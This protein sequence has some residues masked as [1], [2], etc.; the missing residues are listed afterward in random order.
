MAR[1]SPLAGRIRLGLRWQSTIRLE[2][3]TAQPGQRPFDLGPFACHRVPQ[4]AEPMRLDRWLLKHVCSNWN[5][6]Q[7]LIAS[8]QVWVLGPQSTLEQ[9]RGSV[10]IPRLR[11]GCKGKTTLKPQDFVYFPKVM[12]PVPKRREPAPKEPPG[13]LLRRLIY[14]D[15]DFLA[16]DKPIGWSVNPGKHVGGAHLQKLL[17]SLKFGMEEAPKFVHRL[18]TEISGVLLLGRHKA[19][20]AYAKDM[21]AQRAFWQ[22]ELWALVC[23]RTPKSGQVSMPL[24][25]E[26]HAKKHVA[27]PMREDDGGLPALTE[28][29]NIR[30][31]PLAGGLT[32]LSMNPYSGRYHQTRAHCAFGLRAPIVGDPVYYD[33]SNHLSESEDFKHRYHSTESRQE[34]QTLLGAQRRLHLHSRQLT[35]KTFAGK[36]ITVTAPVPQHMARSFQAL[37]WQD[38]LRRAEGRAQRLAPWRAE[39]DKH[40]MEA[41]AQVRKETSPHA[42]EE[43][44]EADVLEDVEE[45]ELEEEPEESDELEEP[46][47]FQDVFELERGGR[48][49][50]RSK[51][52]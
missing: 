25:L 48:R 33:L 52:R 19:A 3:P 21:I 30:Y 1:A 29:S 28:Y 16:I 43:A 27:K 49:G 8:K 35:L 37:G 39:E 11:P 14:K 18:S 5:A 36:E 15:T 32:L 9:H 6:R 51:R 31:S 46:D 10:M 47:H 23:G 24:S 41:L 40:L 34:R 20:V 4:D 50:R 2:N 26:R 42:G 12:T 44:D 7:K 17:P 22:R 13:W 38:W 45:D